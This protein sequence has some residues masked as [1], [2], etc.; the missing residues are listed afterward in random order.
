MG[1]HKGTQKRNVLYWVQFYFI[2]Q[3][4]NIK[5]MRP[6]IV[7]SWFE[8]VQ[9]R[10]LDPR[11]YFSFLISLLLTNILESNLKQVDSTEHLGEQT[12]ERL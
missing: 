11:D 10:K 5:H 2:W 4:V 9:E 12:K 6:D 1:F 3:N 7:S 8:I